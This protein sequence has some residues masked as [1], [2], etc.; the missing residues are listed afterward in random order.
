MIVLPPSFPFGGMENPRLTFATP[1]IIAGDRS[2]TALI[3]HEMAH[4]WSG[5][6]VTNATLRVSNIVCV[7][8]HQSA[9]ALDP[10]G[11]VTN[12][13][14]TVAAARTTNYFVPR[15]YPKHPDTY[16]FIWYNDVVGEFTIRA[17]AQDNHGAVAVSEPLTVAEVPADVHYLIIGGLLTNG[18]CKLCMLGVTNNIY[19]V[20]ANTNLLT[21]NWLAIGLME[22]TTGLWRYS[23]AEATNHQ[24]RFYRARQ[25]P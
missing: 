23:D 2:L 16:S 18:A 9:V 25:V 7:P 13:D 21:T 17:V 12:L 1:T 4:S 8:F 6:L 5:N 3:A 22:H 14:F 24:Q 11:V 10:D 15:T 20:L 19:E